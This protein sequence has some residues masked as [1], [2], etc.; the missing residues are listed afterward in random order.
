MFSCEYNRFIFCW[1]VLLYF[2]SF[3]IK[4]CYQESNRSELFTHNNANSPKLIMRVL[5]PLRFK[6]S[7]YDR[8]QFKVVSRCDLHLRSQMVHITYTLYSIHFGSEL[9]TFRMILLPKWHGDPTECVSHAMLNV[10]SQRNRKTFLYFIF[11]VVDIF[12]Q[13]VLS[14]LL[15]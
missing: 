2:P 4:T 8:P 10:V 1:S 6:F 15:I 12:T 7:S 3:E 13:S 11:R 9:R 14:R 5:I